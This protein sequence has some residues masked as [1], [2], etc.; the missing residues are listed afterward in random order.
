[1]KPLRCVVCHR[2]LSWM[3]ISLALLA[4]SSLGANAPSKAGE[5]R[6]LPPGQA[7]ADQRLQPPKDLD[8]Y[9]PFVPPSSQEQWDQRREAVQH[10][11]L[12]SQGLWPMPTKTPLNAVIHGRVEREDYTV[13][14]A[15][16]ESMPGFYV[17]GSLYRPQGKDG[18]RPGV[19]CPHGHWA[20]GR[21]HDAG[22]DA[23]RKEIAQGAEKFEEGGRS[24]LQARCVQLARMGCVVFHYD[25]IGYADS[26]QISF[27]IAHRFAKQREDMNAPENWGL[28]S[29]QAESYLQSVM[30]L[31]TY[32]SI[33]ALDF[34]SS[35][36]D[37]DP[38]RIGVTGASGGGT[39]TFILCAIDPRPAVSLPAVMV[40]TAMQ[41]GCTCENA[42]CLRVGTGNVEFAGLFAPKPLALT[43]A[44][45][46]T[47]EME[48]KGFPQLKQ[49]YQTVGAPANVMLMAAIQFGH[50]YNLVS[51]QVMYEWFNQ[52]LG[53]G[54]ADPAAEH[55]YQRLTQDEMT[56]WGENHPKPDG[57]PEFERKLLR[58][59]KED[60]DRQ[61]AELLPKDGDT[62]TRFRSQ[63][64]QALAVV[65]APGLPAGTLKF[66]ETSTE[67]CGSYHRVLGLLKSE[68]QGQELPLLVL[69]PR[70][71]DAKRVVLWLHPDGKAGLVDE[72]GHPRRP[73][74]R[75]LEAGTT[76]VGVDLLY[77]GELL[78]E[79]RLLEKTPRVKNTREA[80]A[81]TLGYNPAVFASRA[82]D[83]LAVI[84]YLRQSRPEASIDLVGLEG[85]GHW[86]AAARC[87][88]GNALRSAAI[89]TGGFRFL[90]VRDLQHPDFLPG[91][92]K[93]GDILGMLAAAETAPL[94]LAGESGSAE[95]VRAAFAAADAS[96]KL[97]LSD[98]APETRVASAVDW[99]LTGP[100]ER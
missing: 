22:L 35:L 42:C 78:A 17:T 29:P 15:Y 24:P 53:L 60:A 79:D 10:Q 95:W 92:A 41:G 14:R 80:A 90:G 93:Y 27:D 98:A 64:G 85:A 37:V 44:N 52:H 5:L 26:V 77:Q 63:A 58:W 18:K 47:K 46:W 54:V 21:F 16:F 32:N 4:A 39:Q 70:E 66:V 20:N 40:S 50:N 67:D 84:A 11:I 74:Q 12:V 94:W 33:R 38:A 1:M 6:A 71:A 82:Q 9:F 97:H 89:D 73:I 69:R 7:P 88:A 65:V 61:W 57:G 56:V 30:G 68:A 55:D 23:V 99:L 31:Q 76:V 19:L 8:G 59:W 43:A 91:G 36:P 45:D 34:L 13:E 72:E 86:A 96:G 87:R 83:A 2:R 48:T 3:A 49:L 62:L 28:Y 51:R 100:F 75:L 25:M 81:Y